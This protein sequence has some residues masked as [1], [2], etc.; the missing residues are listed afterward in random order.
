MITYSIKY[1][2][3]KSNSETSGSTEQE[4]VKRS[5]SKWIKSNRS[6]KKPG[7]ELQQ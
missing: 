7:A 4:H 5:K 3:E 6:L 1:F 2:F